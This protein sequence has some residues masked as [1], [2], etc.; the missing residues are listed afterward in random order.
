MVNTM[1]RW[2]EAV[3]KS[4]KDSFPSLF[5][6][7]P[8]GLLYH[9]TS[10]ESSQK[11]LEGNSI[12]FTHVEFMND[13]HEMR[14]GLD[15]FYQ[16]VSLIIKNEHDEKISYFLLVLSCSI[17]ARFENEEERNG[18]FSWLKDNC[19]HKDNQEQYAVLSNVKPM[20][21]YVACFS[22]EEAKDSLPMWYMYADHGVGVCLGF[23]A[24]NLIEA[25][26]GHF[27]DFPEPFHTACFYGYEGTGKIPEFK[28]G[29][30]NFIN[31]IGNLLKQHYSN[32]GTPDQVNNAEFLDLAEHYLMVAILAFKHGA[33]AHE[34]EWRLFTRVPRNDTTH[35][36][37]DEKKTPCMRPY[38]LMPYNA[39]AKDS[40]KEI[41]LGPAH[42]NEVDIA[43]TFF[44][45]KSGKTIEI[46]KSQIPFRKI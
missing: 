9:Y 23:D 11:I 35:V 30:A 37:F 3:D 38:I 16:L 2:F 1:N 18:L 40:L 45:Q 4:A 17:I 21:F 44:S 7:G 24:E 8:R 13:H 36:S 29:I 22:A 39:L 28:R 12:R 27:K 46:K 6:P 14:Y 5:K 31:D 20:D 33:F 19:F 32:G 43:K 41:W 10:C 42:P 34:S 25:H 26:Q 15:W